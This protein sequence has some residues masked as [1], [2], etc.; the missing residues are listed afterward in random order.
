MT[1]IF[2]PATWNPSDKGSA[3]TLSNGNLTAVGVITNGSVRSTVPV[4][5]GKWAWEITSTGSRY[6]ILGVGNSSAPLALHPGADANG[7]GWQGLVASKKYNY[8]S[9]GYGTNW[10][11]T[12]HVVRVE[13]DADTGTVRLFKNNVD[14]GELITGLT[15][16]F[17]AMTGGDTDG[18]GSSNTTANFGATAFVDAPSSGYYAGFGTLVTVGEVISDIT[19]PSPTLLAY[20]GGSLDVASPAGQLS[21]YGG[22][23]FDIVASAGTLS[24]TGHNSYGENAAF[25]T[26]PS[27]SLLAYCGG[28][29]GI[30]API[31]TLS[32]T[33]TGTASL[34]AAVTA[35]AG[36]L[37]A[38]GTVS[39]VASLDITAPSGTLVGYGGAV[40]SITTSAGT[41]AA[42]GI[43]GGVAS[44]AVTA[45]L[46]QLVAS[47]TAQNHGSLLITAPAG[48]LVTGSQAY[49]IAPAGILTAIGTATITATYEAYA[50][51]LKHQP[52]PGKEPNDEVTRY[53]NFPFTH[54]VRYKNSYFGANST[55]LYLLEGTTDYASPTPTPVPWAFKTAMTDFKSQQHKT[56]ASAYFGGRLGAAATVDLHV[57]EDGPQ[58]YS[59]ATVRTDHAQ[60]YR[61]VFGKG[62]KARYYALGASGTGT[63]ELDDIDLDVHTLSRRI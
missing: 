35:P 10:D 50:V 62:T 42:T 25:I 3:C 12:A 33:A 45:P 49:I 7:V 56:V 5:S 2:T 53:T 31:G 61:Q 23:R 20:C 18:G 60:N 6:P 21:S 34:R 8:V 16:P 48:R 22:S 47:V 29:A 59:Y 28:T 51:N 38:T 30:T 26:S 55:G 63:L 40:C 13:L 36:M 15:G 4:T 19:G 32:S 52:K 39:C 11:N 27:P 44:V 9:S 57:G 1:V 46:F 54:I 14:M 17:F 41:L 43:G 58:T 37:N 24:S